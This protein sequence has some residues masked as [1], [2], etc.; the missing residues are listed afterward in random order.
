[1]ARSNCSC[2]RPRSERIFV[3]SD[4]CL[5]I[6]APSSPS[7]SGV[8]DG[9]LVA[10]AVL[11]EVVDDVAGVVVLFL[12]AA[13]AINSVSASIDFLI[14]LIL[15]VAFAAFF[16]LLS[17]RTCASWTA[18]V[19]I[20][21]W[22]RGRSGNED[23]LRRWGGRGH[24]RLYEDRR[25]CAFV[26]SVTVAVAFGV[27]F[28]FLCLTGRDVNHRRRLE[29]ADFVAMHDRGSGLNA[30]DLLQLSGRSA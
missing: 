12:Q 15:S 2:V 13:I 28:L 18:A 1:M 30:L 8:R 17:R 21:L 20:V 24:R 16:L 9:A 11:P 6:E 5:W 25:L 7:C 22:R 26:F 3:P 29:L 27:A 23:G 14:V 19:S 4:G 10:T